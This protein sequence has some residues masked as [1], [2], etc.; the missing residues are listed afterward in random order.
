MP[1]LHSFD[2]AFELEQS[3]QPDFE[4]V[5]SVTR[6]RIGAK[7]DFGSGPKSFLKIRQSLLRT[8]RTSSNV[9]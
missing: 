9:T 8:R 1:Q 7:E 4:I 6:Y 3:S 5:C 2:D